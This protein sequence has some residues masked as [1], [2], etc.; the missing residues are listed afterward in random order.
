MLQKVYTV[1][2]R[3]DQKVPQITFVVT[4]SDSDMHE[5]DPRQVCRRIRGGTALLTRSDHLLLV[6]DLK[7]TSNICFE[8]KVLNENLLLIIKTHPF[9]P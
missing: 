2:G 7:Q 4:S 1:L 8:F 6:T 5:E 3:G 9:L